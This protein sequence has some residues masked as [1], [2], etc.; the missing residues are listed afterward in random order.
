MIHQSQ[1]KEASFDV[2]LK[3]KRTR[4][5]ERGSVVLVVPHDESKAFREVVF[6]SG[7]GVL[8]FDAATSEPC[9][10]NSIGKRVCYHVLSAWK[11]REAN[12]KRRATIAAKRAKAA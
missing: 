10:A 7:G 9:Q 5:F 2:R 8:C 12:R 11:R 1:I 6:L 3:A 4:A